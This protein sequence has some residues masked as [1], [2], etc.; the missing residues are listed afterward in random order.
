MTPLLIIGLGNPGKKYETTRHNAG[1]LFLDFL[2]REWDFPEFLRN[3]RFHSSLSDGSFDG[4][5]IILAQPETFMNLSGDAAEKLMYFYKIPLEHLAVIHDDLDITLGSFRIATNSS[6]AG[7]NGVQSII[8]H[9]GSK[10]F[11]RFRLGIRTP[12]NLENSQ[13]KIPNDRFVLEP[14]P[15]KELETLQSIFPEIQTALESWIREERMLSA[16]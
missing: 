15:E 4:Q 14:F 8:D 6:S 7:H 13:P 10:T 2:Q 3:E 5:K 11:H 1:F 16:S 9:I 12:T